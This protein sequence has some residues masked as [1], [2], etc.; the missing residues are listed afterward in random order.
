MYCSTV[1][2]FGLEAS[3]LPCSVLNSANVISL[4]QHC[5]EAGVPAT[6]S[7]GL[8]GCEHFAASAG[9]A[10]IF[11]VVCKS[12]CEW[13]HTSCLSL[14]NVTSH[15]TMPAPMRAAASYD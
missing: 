5:A 13:R 1:V 2:A 12:H 11:V 7:A 4:V 6:G 8:N 3:I 10:R 14:V 9:T 15:S